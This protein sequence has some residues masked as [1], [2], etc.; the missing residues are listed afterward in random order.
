MHELYSTQTILAFWAPTL[1]TAQLL[2]TFTLLRTFLSKWR[3]FTH[4]TAIYPVITNG[5]F[6]MKRLK[7]LKRKVCI[8]L[9]LPKRANSS[10]LYVLHVAVRICKNIK[11]QKEGDLYMCKPG[12]RFTK[13]KDIFSLMEWSLIIKIYIKQFFLQQH[14]FWFS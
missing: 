7:R 14:V 11:T 6:F 5:T 13:I 8:F 9:Y 4:V 3:I 10:H 2:L 1:K 12:L